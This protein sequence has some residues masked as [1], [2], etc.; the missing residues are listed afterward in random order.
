VPVWCRLVQRS[1]VSGGLMAFVGGSCAVRFRRFCSTI[2]RWII[3]PVGVVGIWAR[4]ELTGLR[5]N[6][7]FGVSWYRVALSDGPS[8]SAVWVEPVGKRSVKYTRLVYLVRGVEF[9]AS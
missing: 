1:E 4:I 9:D 8:C 3:A 6:R 5:W 7:A 2:F